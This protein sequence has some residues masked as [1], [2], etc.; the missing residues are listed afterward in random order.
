MVFTSYFIHIFS[1][2]HFRDYMVRDN[3]YSVYPRLLT[4]K[5]YDLKEAHS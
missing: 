1:I 5:F 2:L 3:T 4:I